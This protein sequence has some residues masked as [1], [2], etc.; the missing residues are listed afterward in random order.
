MVGK[1]VILVGGI[2]VALVTFV[3][4][5]RRPVAP[6]VLVTLSDGVELRVEEWVRGA[7]RLPS[8]MPWKSREKLTKALPFGLRKILFNPRYGAS[9]SRSFQSLPEDNA[10][11]VWLRPTR[12]GASVDISR[13]LY[14]YGVVDQYGW[15][16]RTSGTGSLQS[17]FFPVAELSSLSFSA[18][19]RWELAPRLVALDRT[20]KREVGRAGLPEL[21][22]TSPVEEWEGRP[23]PQTVV[24]YEAEFIMSPMRLRGVRRRYTADSP[25]LEP[26]WE[27]QE[28]R[29]VERD[30]AQDAW[31]VVNR[32]YRDN[33]GNVSR[34]PFPPYLSDREDGLEPSTWRVTLDVVGDYRAAEAPT[35]FLRLPVAWEPKF[36][37][38]DHTGMDREFDERRLV[39]AG[40]IYGGILT[41]SNE[42]FS[43]RKEALPGDFSERVSSRVRTDEDGARYTLS[44][45]QTRFPTVFVAA[46]NAVGELLSVRVLDSELVSLGYLSPTGGFLSTEPLFHSVSKELELSSWRADLLT[47][48]VQFHLEIALARKESVSFTF[49]Q[50]SVSPEALIPVP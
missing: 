8:K 35:E 11:H 38:V 32:I 20:S 24:A 36:G 34:N 6:P 44:T 31:H 45:V 18:L 17:G 3:W 23:L 19:P 28:V 13:N 29:V 33:W 37:F 42:V 48:H 12:E 2:A 43:G 46:E 10:R 27:P 7:Y 26:V 22:A 5:T 15:L 41:F 16:Y 40:L 25:I 1:R 30:G 14:D 50:P 4:L 21:H 39:Y 9:D 47:N 49:Q